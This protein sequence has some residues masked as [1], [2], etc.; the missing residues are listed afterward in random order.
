M[1]SIKSKAIQVEWLIEQIQKLDI[2]IDKHQSGGSQLMADQYLSRKRRFLGE[3]IQIL[4]QSTSDLEG[5]DSI[6]LIHELSSNTMVSYAKSETI[7]RKH[8]V[9]YKKTLAYY[10]I[11][12]A[13]THKSLEIVKEDPTKYQVKRKTIPGKLK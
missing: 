2:M 6:N 9:T 3:L 12:N 11:G 8:V 5:L 1:K 13:D 4:A 7:K 10:K